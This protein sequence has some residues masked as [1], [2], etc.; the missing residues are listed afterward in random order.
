MVPEQDNHKVVL[1]VDGQDGLEAITN[2]DFYVILM[3][4]QMPIMDGYML[5]E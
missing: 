2:N 5:E 3:D 4:V 1:A